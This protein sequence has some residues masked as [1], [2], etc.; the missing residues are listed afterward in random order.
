MESSP[1]VLPAV[2]MEVSLL[3]L[4]IVSGLVEI[5]GGLGG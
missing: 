1:L 2:A 3:D 4:H 5:L